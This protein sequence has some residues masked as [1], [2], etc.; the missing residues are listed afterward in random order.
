[1]I[2]FLVMTY[3]VLGERDHHWRLAHTAPDEAAGSADARYGGL[4]RR[5]SLSVADE[6]HQI[7]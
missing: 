2:F 5:F 4:I 3:E 6:I 1:M 7:Y